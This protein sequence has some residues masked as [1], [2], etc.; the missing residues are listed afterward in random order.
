MSFLRWEMCTKVAYAQAEYATFCLEL[1]SNDIII[2][3]W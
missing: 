2:K 3:L 1:Y